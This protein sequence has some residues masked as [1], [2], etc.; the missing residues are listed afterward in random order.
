MHTIHPGA[1]GELNAEITRSV[2][3]I[4]RAVRGRGPTQ[5]RAWFRGDVVVVVLEGICTPSE[6]SLVAGGRSEEAARMRRDMHGV[7]EGLLIGAVARL[8]GAEVRVLL[9]D[10]AHDPDVAVEV[11]MLDRAVDASGN[12]ACP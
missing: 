4:Y 2:V 6:R 7:M 12:S 5:A 11:F 8:T 1:A 9:G 10:G 3:Q